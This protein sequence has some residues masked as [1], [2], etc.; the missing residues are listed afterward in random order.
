MVKMEEEKKRQDADAQKERERQEA[1]ERKEQEQQ[2]AEEKAGKE[3]LAAL[4]AKY[5]KQKEEEEK[6]KKAVE[7]AEWKAADEA[8][9]AVAEA[10]KEKA[11]AEL[12]EKMGKN[13][14]KVE[15]KAVGTRVIPEREATKVLHLKYQLNQLL[16]KSPIFVESDTSNAS[17]EY[18]RG[19]HSCKSSMEAGPS[20]KRPLAKRSKMEVGDKGP[21]DSCR[22]RKEECILLLGG[23]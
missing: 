17:P 11:A 8:K 5:E 1:E 3:Q 4:M 2:E 20:T 9:K 13:K 14:K 22:A 7:E 19:K 15:E 16:Q 18:T 23:K 10:A 21:C 12:K 6:A